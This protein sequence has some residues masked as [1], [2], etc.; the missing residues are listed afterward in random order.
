MDIDREQRNL[1]ANSHKEPRKQGQER[2]FNPDNG[3]TAAGTNLRQ[4]MRC[5]ST[6]V[7]TQQNEESDQTDSYEDCRTGLHSGVAFRQA[8]TEQ[9]SD[10]AHSPR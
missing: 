4:P 8:A 2:H 1:P 6:G 5:P 10:N 7:E 3:R 9:Q